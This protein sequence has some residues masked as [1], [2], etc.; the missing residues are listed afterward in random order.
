MRF[1]HPTGEGPLAR[2]GR[3]VAQAP[4]GEVHGLVARVAELDPI[5]SVARGSGQRE[6]VGRNQL[7]EAHRQRRTRNLHRGGAHEDS[8]GV[9]GHEQV[10]GGSRGR[11]P[12]QTLSVGRSE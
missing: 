4:S 9:G 8:G 7:V 3:I 1:E 2:F 10:L 11:Q 5:G 12:D 6:A